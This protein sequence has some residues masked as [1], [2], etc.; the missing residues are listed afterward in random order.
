MIW[1]VMGRRAGLR[2]VEDGSSC[3]VLSCDICGQ[4]LGPARITAQKK[5][6][7]LTFFL[8]RTLEFA[9]RLT[10]GHVARAAR[11]TFTLLTRYSHFS[12]LDRV[13]QR[14]VVRNAGSS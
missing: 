2:K 8:H 5:P 6:A 1:D 4:E 12:V 7:F 3:N 13:A 9:E 10:N 11:H 14:T